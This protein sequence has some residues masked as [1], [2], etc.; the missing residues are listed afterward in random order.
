VVESKASQKHV[1][2]HPES[3]QNKS[4]VASVQRN[5]FTLGRQRRLKTVQHLFQGT[6]LEAK[7]SKVLRLPAKSNPA[8]FFYMQ[9]ALK[10]RACQQNRTPA[11][12]FYKQKALKCR[13]CQQNQDD[14][15]YQSASQLE[16]CCLISAVNLW[17]SIYFNEIT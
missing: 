7:S 13:A 9:K 4:L 17:N 15:A 3:P 14:D 2:G 11:E 5:H 10:Y 6:L 12:L 16:K 8:E 1:L